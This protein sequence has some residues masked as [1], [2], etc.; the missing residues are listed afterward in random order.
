[1]K[2]YEILQQEQNDTLEDFLLDINQ[3]AANGW[4]VHTFWSDIDRSITD[5]TG[6]IHNRY[7]RNALLFREKKE[8]K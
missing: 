2:E 7:T 5:A 8:I 1:M 4:E 6:Y 3:M